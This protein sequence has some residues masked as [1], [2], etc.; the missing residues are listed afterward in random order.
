MKEIVI[1]A[2]DS[3]QRLDRFLSKSFPELKQGVVR[4]ALRKN[5][6]KLN[7]KR[8]LADSRLVTGDVLRLYMDELL[9]GKTKPLSRNI[10]REL[11]IIYEDNNLL[12]LDKPPGLP[13]H[14]D[15]DNSP[16]TLIN[17]VLLYLEESGAYNP[18]D[19]F[20]FR[21]ALCNRIDRNTGGIVLAAKN[22]ETLRIISQKLRE[23]EV[24]KL[25]LCA[26]NGVFPN[27]Q[28]AASLTAEL[29]KLPD[30]NIVRVT[31]K[32]TAASKPI[33][34]AYRVLDE[35]GDCSLLEVN[36]LTGRTHQIRAHLAFIGHSLLGDGKYG[37]PSDVFK[38]QALYSYKLRFDFKTSA[39][40]LDYLGGKEFEV[41]D[42]WFLEKYYE[43][44][45]AVM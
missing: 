19:E 45:R 21:P 16:D 5:R 32:K 43:I 29:E 10:P 17:R 27:G 37:K 24:T 8:P 40:I 7:N 22:A 6:I 14:E 34:T 9:A 31:N 44:S 1:G 18:V 11:Q 20:N 4:N 30:K 39:G 2:N 35:R 13:V 33:R 23:R 36:L 42:I 3:G 38:F 26:V 15:N 12:L 28:K 41:K 25:Y